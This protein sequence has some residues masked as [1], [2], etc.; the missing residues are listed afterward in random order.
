MKRDKTLQL[1]MR[2]ACP[3]ASLELMP[4][5]HQLNR[6]VEL[7]T[8]DRFPGPTAVQL[9]ARRSHRPGAAG[10]VCGDPRAPQE[11]RLVVL[12]NELCAARYCAVGMVIGA[13]PP[14]SIRGGFELDGTGFAARA[15]GP[16]IPGWSNHIRLSRFVAKTPVLPTRVVASNPLSNWANSE[17]RACS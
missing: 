16:S 5:S 9:A 13:C 12:S 11:S 3:L 4:L 14:R 8:N 17:P 2:R 6:F 15:I 1:A 7:A 10:A